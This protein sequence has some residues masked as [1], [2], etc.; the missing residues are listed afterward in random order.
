[1]DKIY[2]QIPMSELRIKLP[3]LRRQVQL[4]KMRIVCT[5]Y[6]EVAAFLLPL[7]DLTPLIRETEES[8]DHDDII[9]NTE[10]MSLTQFR[11]QL[12]QSWEKTSIWN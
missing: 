11:D 2:K 4:G 5:H 1:M 9:K 10:D 8:D 7:D 6:G 12:T 3:K